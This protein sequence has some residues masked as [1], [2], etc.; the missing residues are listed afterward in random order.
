MHRR[1]EFG[2]DKG[3]GVGCDVF[4]YLNTVF[5]S[6]L[7]AIANPVDCWLWNSIY[8]NLNDYRLVFLE[9]LERFRYFYK[10]WT[11]C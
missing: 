8:Y 11:L 1:V 10:H 4:V 2:D 9:G 7:F 6:Q 3:V 5:G